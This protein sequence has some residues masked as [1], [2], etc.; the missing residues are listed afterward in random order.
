MVDNRLKELKKDMFEAKN[1]VRSSLLKSIYLVLASIVSVLLSVLSMYAAAAERHTTIREMI[2][3]HIF[4]GEWL[5]I[6][7]S[8]CCIIYTVMMIW[9][10]FVLYREYNLSVNRYQRYRKI[11]KKTQT[12]DYLNLNENEVEVC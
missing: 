2:D 5:V 6:I 11:L 12:N 8:V 3:N 1:N 7:L 4:G 10:S 9:D